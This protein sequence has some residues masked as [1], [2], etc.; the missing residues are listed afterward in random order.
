[1]EASHNAYDVPNPLLRLVSQ[2]AL[3][4]VFG[5]AALVTADLKLA[6]VSRPWDEFMTRSGRSDL[7]RNAL[8]GSSILLFFRNDEQ[9]RVF[10]TL[11]H[12]MHSDELS[13]HSQVVDLG[14]R[15]KPFYV[16]L[17]VQGL[18]QEGVFIGYFVHC[19]DITREHTNRLALIDRDKE[20]HT[21]RDTVERSEQEFSKLNDDLRKSAEEAAQREAQLRKFTEKSVRLEKSLKEALERA[22]KSAEKNSRMQHELEKLRKQQTDSR[23]HEEA[24]TRLNQQTAALSTERDSASARSEQLESELQLLREQLNAGNGYVEK[25]AQEIAELQATCELYENKLQVLSAELE[26]VKYAL[27]DK[28]AELTQT[29]EQAQ[30]TA[31]EPAPTLNWAPQKPSQVR[32]LSRELA[33]EFNNLLTG[34]LGHASLAAADHDGVMSSDILAIEKTAREAAQLVKKLSVLGQS[35]HVGELNLGN[36]LKQHISKLKDDFY[37]VQPSIDLT[38]ECKVLADS[39]ALRAILDAV[40]GFARDQVNEG[41]SVLYN[42]SGDAGT[43]TMS[44]CYEGEALLPPGWYDGMPPAVGQAGWDLIFAREVARGLG[45]ELELYSEN[46]TSE[47]RLTLPLAGATVTAA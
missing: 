27:A 35:R 17:H 10:E 42:L 33:E 32:V 39:Q 16:Q 13:R 9:R 45:G 15:E 6:V 29:R 34:V 44:L 2:P 43:A 25:S 41:G 19:V 40:S 8:T 1:M 21:L 5:A 46:G 14:S 12:S 11:L 3:D 38:D 28:E 23:N 30:A 26:S 37:G 47:C 20:L 36:V 22:E 7:S 31:V 24:L 18:W 4:A